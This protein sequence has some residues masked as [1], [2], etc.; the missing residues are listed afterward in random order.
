PIDDTCKCSCLVG[1][2]KSMLQHFGAKNRFELER[3]AAHQCSPHCSLERLIASALNTSTVWPLL[4]T[5]PHN[6][7]GFCNRLWKQSMPKPHTAAYRIELLYSQAF[8]RCLCHP[9][10]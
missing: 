6:A 5:P 9:K 8:T 4:A 3:P 1:P 2:H 10:T 7:T